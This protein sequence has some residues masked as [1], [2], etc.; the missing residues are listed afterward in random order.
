MEGSP[1]VVQG[2]PS[3]VGDIAYW[4]VHTWRLPLFF[5]LAGFFAKLTMDRYGAEEFARK[6]FKRLVVPF[7]VAAYTI[8]PILYVIFVTGWYLTGKCTYEQMMPHISLPQGL[9]EHI[10][11]PVHMWFLEDLIIMSSVYLFLSIVM[12][13]RLTS[14]NDQEPG[15]A[16]PWW[17]P[18]AAAVPTGLLL[19]S[20]L[21][22]VMAHHNTF[23]ADP[24][25]LL[26]YSIYFIGGIVAFQNLDWFTEAVRFSKLHLLLSV[27]FGILFLLL[28]RTDIIDLQSL[29]GR[30][31]GGMTIAMTAW[32]TIYGLMGYF[33]HHC[34]TEGATARYIADSSYWMYLFHLP[35]VTGLQLALHWVDIPSALKFVIVSI[36]TTLIGLITYQLFVR[37]S[38]IGNYLHGQ[39]LRPRKAAG[40]QEETP[41]LTK[42]EVVEVS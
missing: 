7:V 8:G 39:R 23:L 16:M 26:Y 20:D 15:I 31:V 33:L 13:A 32:L 29:T 10:F 34:K 11:G 30:L 3:F 2:E 41:T 40:E 12:P 25:R 28:L 37:Y 22:P 27:P 42:P 5:F 21:N 35:V 14:T 6:R 18:I 24:P 17:L 38:I 36:V 9:Q 4:W 1:W 19:W